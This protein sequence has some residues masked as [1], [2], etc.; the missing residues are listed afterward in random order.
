MYCDRSLKQDEE[1]EEGEIKYF[2]PNVQKKIRTVDQI[3]ERVQ[4][5]ES[6]VKN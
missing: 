3:K 6:Q 2:A 4:Y 1:I 5:L